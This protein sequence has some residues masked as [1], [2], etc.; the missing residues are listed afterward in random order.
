MLRASGVLLNNM[1]K[2][3]DEAIPF[4]ALPARGRAHRMRDVFK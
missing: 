3:I 4:G 2:W 1:Q